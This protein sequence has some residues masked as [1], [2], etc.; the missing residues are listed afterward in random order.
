MDYIGG[1]PINPFQLICASQSLAATASI[2]GEAGEGNHAKSD[3]HVH[4]RAAH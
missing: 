3:G 1:Q 2:Q 4:R